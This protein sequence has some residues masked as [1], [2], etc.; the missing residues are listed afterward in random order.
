MVFWT[1]VINKMNRIIFH[2]RSS[3]II[4]IKWV[5]DTLFYCATMAYHLGLSANLGGHLQRGQLKKHEQVVTESDVQ[6]Q[7]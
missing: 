1:A 6:W 4:K 7:Y 3:C 5:G 2:E